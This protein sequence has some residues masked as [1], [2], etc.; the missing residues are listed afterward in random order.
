MRIDC[1]ACAATYEVPDRLLAGPARTLRCSRCGA[2]FA[3]PR[4]AAPAPP[5][6]AEPPP[7]APPVPEPQVATEPPPAPPPRPE[8][9]AMVARTPP[10]EAATPRGLVGAW[11][12]S[13][14]VVVAAIL[15]LLAFHAKVMEIWPAS[16]RL[17]AALG[18]A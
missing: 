6:V 12:A 3:L 14:V 5:P 15:G 18:L 9:L 13:L 10:D 1:P 11:I 7:A 17:F 16:T 8:P 4:V 2:D